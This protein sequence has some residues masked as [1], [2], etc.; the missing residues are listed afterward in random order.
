MLT[1]AAVCPHPPLL[2]PQVAAGAAA[3]LAGLRAACD[4]AVAALAASG[5]DVVAVVGAGA[6]DRDHPAGA[7]GGFADFG[8]PLRVGPGEPVLPPALTVGRWLAERAGVRPD[9]YAE[10]AAAAGPE[11]CLARGAALAGAGRRVA[12]LVMGDGS[13][14]NGEAAPAPADPQAPAFDRAVAAA[15]AAADADA[16]ARLEPRAAERLMAQG[17]PAWQVLAGAARALPEGRPLR[18]ELLAHEAPYGV[19]YF[20]AVWTQEAGGVEAAAR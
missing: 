6:R 18:G 13:A 4:R 3:E 8:V 10:V 16:L 20:V 1:A 17:R 14:R 11:R 19:G 9:R 12:L 2:V 15:L 5:P 7:G